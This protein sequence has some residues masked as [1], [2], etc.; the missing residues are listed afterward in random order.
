MIPA[1]VEG[2]IASLTA[3]FLSELHRTFNYNR[4]M[5]PFTKL[6]VGFCTDYNGTY[7][8]NVQLILS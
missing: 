2:T 3:S 6:A 1:F 5:F 4:R 8:D 7:L